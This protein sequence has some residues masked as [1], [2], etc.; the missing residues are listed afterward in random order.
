MATLV[1]APMDNGQSRLPSVLKKKKEADH[2]N[3]RILCW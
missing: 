1:H 3:R 2:R